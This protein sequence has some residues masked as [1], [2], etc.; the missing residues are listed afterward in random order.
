MPPIWRGN[1]R[2]FADL[3]GMPGQESELP[4]SSAP[5]LA[6]PHAFPEFNAR[7]SMKAWRFEQPNLI[8]DVQHGVSCLPAR[9]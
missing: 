8:L 9:F 5:S 1:H 2:G 6:S 7:Q 4:A 3:C